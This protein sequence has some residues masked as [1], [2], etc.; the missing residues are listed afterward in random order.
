MDKIRIKENYEN[1]ER[2]KKAFKDFIHA[3]VWESMDIDDGVHEDEVNNHIERYCRIN[4]DQMIALTN[5]SVTKFIK[6]LNSRFE[7]HLYEVDENGNVIE[8]TEKHLNTDNGVIAF[9]KAAEFYRNAKCPRVNIF[10]NEL[11]KYVAV[12]D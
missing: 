6:S 1:Y 3:L 2:V 5:D 11:G 12:W 8:E 4:G 7:V 9:K 10:D